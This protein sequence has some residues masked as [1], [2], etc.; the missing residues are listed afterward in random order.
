MRHALVEYARRVLADGL[1]TG[2]SGNRSVRVGD[3]RV[4]ITPSGVDYGRLTPASAP[5]SA[6]VSR[7]V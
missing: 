3:E 5:G 7:R 6:D 1:V 4:L 2:T